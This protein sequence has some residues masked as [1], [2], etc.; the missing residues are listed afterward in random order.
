MS[1]SMGTLRSSS[2][3]M[4]GISRRRIRAIRDIH[5][6]MADMVRRTRGRVRSTTIIPARRRTEHRRWATGMDIRRRR[7]TTGKEGM[8]MEGIQGITMRRSSRRRIR[9]MEGMED[10]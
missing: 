5:T 4:G 1:P 3:R 2:R 9:V 7:R 10:R 8:D 6:A